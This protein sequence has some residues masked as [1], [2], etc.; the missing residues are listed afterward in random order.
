MQQLFQNVTRQPNYADLDLDFIPNPTTG[1][2]VL[3]RGIDAIKRSVRNLIFTNFY[4]RKFRSWIGSNA[5]GLLFELVNPLTAQFLKD[6]INEVITNYEPR[7]QIVD[8]GISVSPNPDQNGYDV[9]ISFIIINRNLPA[10]ISFFLER[11][12]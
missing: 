10:Q 12:R 1:D 4:D 5:R 9:S 7:V 3:K 11:I 8:R 6:A 2:I